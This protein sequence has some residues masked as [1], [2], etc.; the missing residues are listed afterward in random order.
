MTVRYGLASPVPTSKTA[1][2]TPLIAVITPVFRGARHLAECLE[3][4][5][6]QEHQNW[7]HIVVDNASDDDTRAIAAAAAAEDSRVR[8]VA[9]DV[10]VPMLDNWNRALLECPADAEYVMQVGADDL[11]ADD[12][13]AR[14]LDVGQR[15]PSAQVIA[16][17][18]SDGSIT[19]PVAFD[20][21]IDLIAGVEVAR[22]VLLGGTDVIG[23]PS[24][25]MMRRDAIPT[26]TQMYDGRAWPPGMSNAPARWA[27]DKE[28]FLRMLDGGYVAFTHGVLTMSRQDNGGATSVTEDLRTHCAGDLELLLRFAERFLTRAEL[29][30][31][32]RVLAV[33]YSAI[34]ANQTLR[35]GRRR[36]GL[37]VEYHSR[38]LAHVI[39]ALREQGAPEAATALRA[40]R[41]MLVARSA[42]AGQTAT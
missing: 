2:D 4:V 22:E 36:D 31:R 19:L 3:A 5:R 42:T 38:A 28:P 20:E 13:F 8:L 25:V 17:Y 29:R 11:I 12:C 7:C 15:Y 21:S 24:N 37:F 18:R 6:R 23:S 34:I 10:Y 1:L 26:G 33:R 9:H 41:R 32:A 39:P 16:A 35:R 40:A 30:R 27:V 14:M